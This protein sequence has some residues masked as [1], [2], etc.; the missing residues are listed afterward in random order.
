MKAKRKIEFERKDLKRAAKALKIALPDNLG[1]VVYAI[2]YRT[3]LPRKI[4][5]TQP[6]G[7]EWI[8]E[9]AAAPVTIPLGR[10][11]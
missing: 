7:M 3:P 6:E 4:I 8:I 5:E 11:Q 1:D 2:R 10:G 9:G